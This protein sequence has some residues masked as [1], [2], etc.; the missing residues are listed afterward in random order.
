MPVLCPG[1]AMTFGG[2][3][4]PPPHARSPEDEP[5]FLESVKAVLMAHPAPTAEQLTEST[6]ALRR[7]IRRYAPALKALAVTLRA[8]DPR[9]ALAGRVADGGFYRAAQQ[10][11]PGSGLMSARDYCRLLLRAAYDIRDHYEKLHLGKEAPL[12]VDPINPPPLRATALALILRPAEGD[13]THEPHVLMVGPDCAGE[14][15]RNFRLPGGAMREGEAPSHA[16]VREVREETG[17]DVAPARML[18][19]DWVPATGTA[20]AGISLVYAVAPLP[21]EPEVKLPLP[22]PERNAELLSYKWVVVDELDDYCMPHQ[23]RRVRAAL[24][25][26]R[27]GDVAELHHGVSAYAAAA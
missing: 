21:G 23:A 20:P 1:T 24:A 12:D 8:D 4:I 17:L 10:D 7:Y 26:L 9:R 3:P 5:A 22:A 18:V 15:G 19:H 11:G 16:M 14:T 25:A 27:N 13:G 2:G 6:N